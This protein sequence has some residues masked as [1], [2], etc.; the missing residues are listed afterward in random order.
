MLL[1]NN[2]YK[3]FEDLFFTDQSTSFHPF[4]QKDKS[5]E[6]VLEVPGFSKDN[7]KIEVEDG[8]VRLNGEAEVGGKKRTLSKYYELPQ[9]ADSKKLSAKLNN[10][11]LELL[12]PRKDHPKKIPISIK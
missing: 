10:G 9:K 11:I 12:I 3:I 1:H 6:A 8:Y 2:P 4:Q 7:L 5:F